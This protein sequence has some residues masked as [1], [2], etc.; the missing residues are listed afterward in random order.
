MVV[1]KDV[2][3]EF[4]MKIFS[5]DLDEVVKEFQEKYKKEVGKLKSMDFFE[6]IICGD[7]EEWNEVLNK[8]GLNVLIIS[9]KSDKKRKLDVK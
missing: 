8:V 3:M 6:Y 1:V 4:M 9:L 5:D 2:V 7:D